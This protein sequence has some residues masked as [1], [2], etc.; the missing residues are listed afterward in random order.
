MEQTG[1]GCDEAASALWRGELD[2]TVKGGAQPGWNGV[3]SLFFILAFTFE[4]YI[5][6]AF[7][8]T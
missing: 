8:F 6:L 2:F 1:L 5:I 4:A 7:Q 3:F